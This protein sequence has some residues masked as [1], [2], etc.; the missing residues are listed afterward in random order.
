MTDFSKKYGP[1]AIVTGAS[2]GLGEEF[3]RQLASLKLNL[4]LIARRKEKLE[5]LSNELMSKHGVEIKIIP[6]DISHPDFLKQI[7]AVTDPLD[8]GLLINNAGFALTGNFLEHTIEDELSLLYVNCRAPLMLAH[9]FGKKMVQRERGGIINVSSVAAFL[10][11]PFWTTYSASK[12]YDLHFSEGLWFELKGKGVDI[13]ALC[14]GSTRTEFSK[15]AGTKSGGME[16]AEVVRIGLK[17]LGKKSTVI[18][19]IN[20]RIITFLLK[21]FSR[22]LL[23][24]IGA[25]V[26]QG[27]IARN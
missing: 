27:S 5:L 13:L 21:F 20:N 17:F 24:K 16:P 9:S 1:W 6:T 4:V 19:G 26:V 12:V 3:A 18:A 25:R 7:Q 15:V 23:I 10:P 14:P 8:V 2:S 11:M 22:Q